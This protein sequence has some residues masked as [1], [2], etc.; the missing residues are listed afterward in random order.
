MRLREETEYK[1]K[2]LVT[3]GGMPMLWHIMKIYSHY[4]IREF[5]LCLG[6][7]ADMIKEYFLSFEEMM[8]DF[9]LDLRAKES[10]VMHHGSS[11]EDWK[12]TFVNTGEEA[13]TGSRIAQIEPYVKGEA[14]CLTYGDGV[15]NI[16]IGKLVQ[17]H[18]EK[19]KAVTLTAVHPE[20]VFGIVEHSGG[21]V[22]SFKEKPRGET[23]ING[24]FFV[25]EPEVFSY[26]SRDPSCVFEQAPLRRLAENGKLGAYDHG[27]FWYCMDTYKHFEDLNKR[28]ATGNAPWKMWN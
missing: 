19:G 13:N 25:C 21:D 11:L 17:F 28:W 6:Y 2:P 20:S 15:A 16:D 23:T 1:P 8:N 10:R 4:G 5:V 24:G 27:D 7:K 12:I 14:F 9:T 22:M 3:I 18:R 26:L